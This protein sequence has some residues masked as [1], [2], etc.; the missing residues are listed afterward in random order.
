MRFDPNATPSKVQPRSVVGDDLSNHHDPPVAAQSFAPPEPL[1]LEA[2]L[3][4]MGDVLFDATVWRR[5]FLRLLTQ[6]GLHTHYRVFY[7]VLDRD[8]LVDVYCGRK[9]FWLALRDY[10]QSIGLGPAHIDEVLA[11]G[12]ARFAELTEWIRPLP[13]VA[14]TLAQLSAGGLKMTAINNSF[15][16]AAELEDTLDRLGLRSYL[17]AV[18]SSLDLGAALPSPE[19]FEAALSALSLPAEKVGF[20]G[21]DAAELE[22]ARAMG[23]A[24]IAFN[25]DPGAV[26]DVHLDRFDLLPD[27]IARAHSQVGAG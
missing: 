11:A 2:L 12:Q 22:G 26:A 27:C 24:T 21:H 17:P 1:Q 20:V 19:S 13:Q 3:F 10:L 7:G 18:I 6:T 4:D 15:C 23:M 16:P 5:W 14:A 9:D 25:Y 8:Y